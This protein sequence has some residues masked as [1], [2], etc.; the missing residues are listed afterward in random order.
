[1]TTSSKKIN[2]AIVI[3]CYNEFRTVK[4]VVDLC[5]GYADY[6]ILVDD[7]STDGSM[8]SLYGNPDIH[9]ITFTRNFGKGAAIREGLRHASNTGCLEIVLLDADLQH[10]PEKLPEFFKALENADIVIGV[11]KRAGTSMPLARKLSNVITTALLTLRTGMNFRDSQCGFRA[12]RGSIIPQILPSGNG[13]EAETEMLI[14]AAKLKPRLEFVQIPTI[15]GNDESK[16][17]ALPAIL[18]FLKVLISPIR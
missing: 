15:Y 13:F 4:Q 16:M 12:Y 11:R 9:I 18:G 3:P 5:K 10:P 2:K 17:K 6:I 7:G 1:M 8:E 14:K